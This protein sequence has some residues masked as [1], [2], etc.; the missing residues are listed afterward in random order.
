VQAH[1]S[2]I[3]LAIIV[4]SLVP[5]VIEVVNARREGA[6]PEDGVSVAGASARATLLRGARG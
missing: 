3:V 1:F 2:V 4:I 6:R 5:I